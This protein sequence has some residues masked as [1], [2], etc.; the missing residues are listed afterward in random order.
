LILPEARREVFREDSDK[1]IWRTLDTST[2]RRTK[3]T[4]WLYA[5]ITNAITNKIHGMADRIRTREIQDT[6]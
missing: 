1:E 6:Y 3:V 2:D 4:E 5:K